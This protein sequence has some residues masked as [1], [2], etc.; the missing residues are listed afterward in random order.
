[1]KQ[2]LEER[3]VSYADCLEKTDL[4][5]RLKET[6]GKINEK[7]KASSLGFETNESKIAQL[8]CVILKPN[9]NQINMAVIVCHGFGANNYD[10]LP[11]GS[12]IMKMT[13]TPNIAFVFPNGPLSLGG[14]S[15]A[16]WEIDMNQMIMRAMAGRVNEM[17]QEVPPSLPDVRLKIMELVEQVKKQFNLP[18]SKI[19]LCGF[20]QGSMLT[21]DVVLHMNEKP[22]GLAVFSGALVAQSVWSQNKHKLKG[23]K[24]LQSHGLNDPILPFVLSTFLKSFFEESGAEVEFIS[25]VDGHTVPVNVIEKFTQIL[26]QLSS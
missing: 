14:T 5:N 15:K 25:F 17:M 24:I 16:W 4:I 3:G 6:E 13:P 20:S 26:L 23:L 19:F 2:K 1:L 21:I 18:S 8:D 11:I 9:T 22:A 10:L 7:K 12:T